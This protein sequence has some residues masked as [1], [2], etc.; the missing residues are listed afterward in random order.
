MLALIGFCIVH[1]LIS[2]ILT[3]LETFPVLL[4]ECTLFHYFAVFENHTF[5]CPLDAHSISILVE[6]LFFP[7]TPMFCDVMSL[8]TC[9]Y[10]NV[11]SPAF[12]SSFESRPSTTAI[13]VY[14]LSPPYGV[15]TLNA[16]LGFMH[17]NSCKVECNYF[18][19]SKSYLKPII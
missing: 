14:L 7:V 8:R 18:Q 12:S 11:F 9:L 19:N 4:I 16:T 6:N 5:F 17:V 15:L 2:F 10:G 1:L 13:P 3:L